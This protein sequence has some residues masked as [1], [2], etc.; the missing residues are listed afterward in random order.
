MPNVRLLLEAVQTRNGRQTATPISHEPVRTDA[1]GA[2]R[3]FG[4]PPGDYLVS[5]VL[6]S[7]YETEGL[8]FDRAYY[9]GSSTVDSAIP[10]RLGWGQDVSGIGLQ[11]R[12]AGTGEI[13]LKLDAG[14][15]LVEFIA[16][17]QRL[18]PYGFTDSPTV[19]RSVRR[20]ATIRRLHAGT[21]LIEARAVFKDPSDPVK[22]EGTRWTHWARQTV[23]IAGALSTEVRLV[24]R[25]TVTIR[26]RIDEVAASGEARPAGGISVQWL[27]DGITSFPDV[28]HTTSE[29][30]GSFLLGG[31][32]PGKY[33]IGLVGNQAVLEDV[34][35]ASEGGYADL[36]LEVV[37]PMDAVVIRVAKR[38]AE[39]T[40]RLLD[41]LGAPLGDRI[42]VIFS[43]DPKFWT[44]PS[45]R[46]AAGRS[47][48]DGMFFLCCVP[49]GSYWMAVAAAESV[50]WMDPGFLEHAAASAVPVDVTSGSTVRRDLRVGKGSGNRR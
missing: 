22:L 16:W 39:I 2:F 35:T 8:L 20:D 50:D 37:D 40:G 24:W 45:R 21:Y 33:R 13:R 27:E 38:P 31:I 10:V 36:P 7:G 1:R 42:V 44:M 23:T 28:P 17:A 30:D 9:P 48:L 6:Q 19:T 14:G 11:P 25:P 4:L 18:S 32:A 15:G 29:L 46:V 41:T 5:A 12:L 47:A 26:G 3:F 49:S 34:E 43:K